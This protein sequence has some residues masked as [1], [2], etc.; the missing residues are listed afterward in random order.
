[1]VVIQRR[2]RNL[3]RNTIIFGLGTFGSKLL[4][5]FLLPLYTAYLTPEMYMAMT[6]PAGA[7]FSIQFFFESPALN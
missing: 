4:V 5:F 2:Y 7:D 3:F 1:M 6:I